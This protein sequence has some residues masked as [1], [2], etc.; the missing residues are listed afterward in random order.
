MGLNI[1]RHV[2]NVDQLKIDL[3]HESCRLQN[4]FLALP[5]HKTDRQTM[6]FLINSRSQCIERGAIAG[7]QGEKKPRCFR[8]LRVH[9]SLFSE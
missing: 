1:Q 3:V 5:L 8:D 2:L 4:W 7:G 6:E 9:Y